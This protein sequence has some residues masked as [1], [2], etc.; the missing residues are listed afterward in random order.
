MFSCTKVEQIKINIMTQFKN[1]LIY[2]NEL[3]VIDDRI[4]L[5]EGEIK[6]LENEFYSRDEM[7]PDYTF[8]NMYEIQRTIENLRRHITFLE[9][10]KKEMYLSVWN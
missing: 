2:R 6:S 3:P 9:Y 7:M 5:I 10:V 1:Y 4:R 8:N